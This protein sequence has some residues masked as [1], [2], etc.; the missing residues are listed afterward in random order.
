MTLSPILFTHIAGG[1]IGIASGMTALFIRKG[2]AWHHKVGKVF[3]YSML[4]MS[5]SAAWLAFMDNSEVS[6]VTGLLTFYLVFT[7]QKTAANRRG[8]IT[9]FDQVAFIYIVLVIALGIY[10]SSNIISTKNASGVNLNGLDYFLFFH[11]G[12]AVLCAMLDLV[13]LIQGGIHGARRMARHL[14]RMV[15]S[16]WIATGSFFLGQQQMF[17]EALRGTLFL[18]GPV[19]LVVV[20]LFFWLIRV[21]VSSRF[22]LKKS[23]ALAIS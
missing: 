7:A 17:P 23:K 12:V 10:Y 1:M 15:F 14:G 18:S 19:I 3:F 5:S 16:L 11:T 4:I 9:K 22:K 13:M 8:T 6:V 2:S 20:M 21:F